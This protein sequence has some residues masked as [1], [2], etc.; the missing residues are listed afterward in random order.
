LRL[1][2]LAQPRSDSL[3][4]DELG[5]DRQVYL[6]ATDARLRRH[7]LYSF[8][9]YQISHLPVKENLLDSWD[10]KRDTYTALYYFDSFDNMELLY[11]DRDI[12]CMYPIP[13]AQR[14][15]H[16]EK[17]SML[18]ENLSNEGEFVLVNT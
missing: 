11:R 8:R 6:K 9:L 17:S 18:D 5:R 10:V 2:V 4:L 14:S 13:F 15:V 12:S 7:K 1:P 16:P 3:G